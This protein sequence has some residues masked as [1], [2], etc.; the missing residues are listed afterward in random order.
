[1]DSGQDFV[2]HLQDQCYKQRSK[3]RLCF[4]DNSKTVKENIEKLKQKTMGKIW[5]SVHKVNV[6]IT[7]LRSNIYQMSP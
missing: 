1:M 4:H 5:V 6:T 7:A 2:A 3:V